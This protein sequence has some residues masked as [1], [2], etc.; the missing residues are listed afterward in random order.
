MEQLP[1]SSLGK[2]LI[3]VG[4]FIVALG[5]VFLFFEK[6]PSIGKL[7]GDIIIRKK[8]FTFYFPITT[9]IILNLVIW[10][11]IWI[12]NKIKG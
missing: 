1:F 4:L 11:I 10:I 8:N 3:G 9:L 5:F 2:F 12:I 7:P 6:L